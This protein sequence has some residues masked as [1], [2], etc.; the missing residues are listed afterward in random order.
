[1]KYLEWILDIIY[2][3]RCPVCQKVISGFGKLICDDCK[4]ALQYVVDPYCL[5]CGKPLLDESKEYC[6]DC[7]SYHHEYIEGRATFVYDEAMKKCMY[8]FKYNNRRE[9]AEYLGK[10][11]ATYLMKKILSWDADAIIPVPVHKKRLMKRGYNQ[12]YLLSKVISKEVSKYKSLPVMDN[13]VKRVKNTSVMKRL[14][15]KQR[16]KNLENAFKIQ[17]YDVKLN[18]VIVVDDIYTTGSTIDAISKCLHHDGVK[19]IYYITA[20][21]GTGM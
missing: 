18:N 3:R 8:A 1:M 4:P 14:S 2:P 17:R 5:K 16:E 19:K 21:I 7:N 12:A 11:T 9:Y 20:C 13:Y 10:E 15:Y 6:D